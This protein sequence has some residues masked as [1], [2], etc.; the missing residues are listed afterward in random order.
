MGKDIIRNKFCGIINSKYLT[1]QN[2]YVIE[3]YANFQKDQVLFFHRFVFLILDY[4]KDQI[5][6]GRDAKK[7]SFKIQIFDSRKRLA[8]NEIRGTS[9]MKERERERQGCIAFGFV[10]RR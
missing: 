6:R 3:N 10:D 7:T 2:K 8:R 5:R 9:E 1:E 4:R